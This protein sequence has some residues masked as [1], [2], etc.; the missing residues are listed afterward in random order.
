VNRAT[1]LNPE[2]ADLF[3]IFNHAETITQ[4]N[5]QTPQLS[6]EDFMGSSGA[7]TGN[8]IGD[9]AHLLGKSFTDFGPGELDW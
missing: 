3:G 2:L 4:V 5:G 1:R 8:P 9:Y 7:A 6:A